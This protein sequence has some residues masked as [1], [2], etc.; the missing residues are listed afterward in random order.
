MNTAGLVTWNTEC[1][2]HTGTW[3][4]CDLSWRPSQ[5]TS[6][7]LAPFPSLAGPGPPYQ[8]LS[9]HRISDVNIGLHFWVA[10]KPPRTPHFLSS[11]Y[12]LHMGTLR[13]SVLT[14][15]PLIASQYLCSF[16]RKPLLLDLHSAFNKFSPYPKHLLI[17]VIKT[18]VLG[19]TSIFLLVTCAVG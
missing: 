8:P 12:G 10:E 11:L 13:S 17:P 2:L 4:G 6:S 7:S 18:G 14:F 19:P 1:G 16:K 5:S 15:S 3:C 9:Y